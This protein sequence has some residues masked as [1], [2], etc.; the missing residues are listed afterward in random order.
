MRNGWLKKARRKNGK[1]IM[2]EMMD[3][4]REMNEMGEKK[5]SVIQ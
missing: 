5:K 3:A 1:Q 2:D 4:K